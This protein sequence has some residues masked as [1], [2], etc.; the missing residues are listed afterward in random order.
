MNIITKFT[1]S[2]KPGIDVLLMLTKA[3]AIEKYSSILEEKLLTRYIAQNFNKEALIA[4]TN[5]M[6]NQWLVVY[7]DDQPAGYARITSK[8]KRPGILDG[9]RAIHIADFGVLQKY[10]EAAVKDSLIEK[11]LIVCRSFEGIWINEH[12]SSPLI[13]FFESNGFFP[14]KE[15]FQLDELP[16]SSVCLIRN[17]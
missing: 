1:L 2:T 8:G 12:S 5:N 17:S 3:L 4:E 15:T 9:K 10:T 14:Q 13:G 16:I 7:V 6:S 11:C